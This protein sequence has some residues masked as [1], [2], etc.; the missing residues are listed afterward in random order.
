MTP[1]MAL[2]AAGPA[3]NL[4]RRPTGVVHIYTG[5]FTPF[6][7][8]PRAYRTVCRARTRALTACPQV[9]GVRMC[10]RCSARLIPQRRAEQ[11]TRIMIATRYRNITA[12]DVVDAAAEAA[13]TAELEHLAHVALV[14]LGVPTCVNTRVT[15]LHAGDRPR[16]I[17]EHIGHHRWRTAGYP[18]SRADIRA[19]ELAA[20]AAA[21]RAARRKEAHEHNEERIRRLGIS[22]AKP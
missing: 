22:L 18:E 1:T 14:V 8:V 2:A 19:A 21:I 11:P 4:V 3:G 16:T 17:A 10:A 5:P 20:G 12:G 7:R 9:R 13:T 15:P 6:G